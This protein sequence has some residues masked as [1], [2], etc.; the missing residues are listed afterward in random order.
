MGDMVREKESFCPC[1][2]LVVVLDR[3][4]TMSACSLTDCRPI[5]FEIACTM[6]ATA[7]YSATQL[8]H[9]RPTGLA[10]GP[11]GKRT[12]R[13]RVPPKISMA[14]LYDTTLMVEQAYYLLNLSLFLSGRQITSE[15]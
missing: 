2:M 8:E 11:D 6:A 15:R 14:D 12:K 9:D 1:C 3:L 5:K 7:A 13:I 10:A 4:S